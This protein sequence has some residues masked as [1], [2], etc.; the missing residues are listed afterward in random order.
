MARSRWLLTN[1]V[2]SDDAGS[3]AS[4]ALESVFSK[5]T[6]RH[7]FLHQAPPPKRREQRARR[8]P[9]AWPRTSPRGREKKSVIDRSKA[10]PTPGGPQRVT[11][12]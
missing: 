2:R 8:S 6:T 4:A 5:I 9:G 10:C 11:A 1:P 7:T 12:G 3:Y